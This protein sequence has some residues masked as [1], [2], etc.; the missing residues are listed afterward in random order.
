MIDEYRL[1]RVSPFPEETPEGRR[2]AVEWSLVC[3]H[4]WKQRE[5]FGRSSPLDDGSVVTTER[6]GFGAVQTRESLS[7]V[8]RRADVDE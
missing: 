7:V 5:L 4:G 8:H 1:L 6:L 2:L 3:I